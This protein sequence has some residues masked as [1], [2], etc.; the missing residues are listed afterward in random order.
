M[1]SNESA[2]A[3]QTFQAE[4]NCIF[5]SR[6][7]MLLGESECVLRRRGGAN[8]EAIKRTIPSLHWGEGPSLLRKEA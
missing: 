2:G 5:E 1:R 6:A 3:E 7:K 8:K 4:G